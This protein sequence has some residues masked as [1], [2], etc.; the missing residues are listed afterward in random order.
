M[1]EVTTRVG[2]CQWPADGR[3]AVDRAS[4]ELRDPVPAAR[5]RPL[6]GRGARWPG[7][8]E[9]DTTHEPSIDEREFEDQREPVFEPSRNV[10]IRFD[11]H[12]ANGILD[13]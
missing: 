9:D 6:R 11:P 1:D 4:R 7:R 13:R 3:R 5:R 2:R 12:R 10:R 8:S